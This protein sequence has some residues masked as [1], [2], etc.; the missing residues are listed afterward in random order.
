MAAGAARIKLI[1]ARPAH[2]GLL[3]WRV[4]K[5][6]LRMPWLQILWK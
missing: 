6:R 5:T 4:P 1:V 2:V 3:K